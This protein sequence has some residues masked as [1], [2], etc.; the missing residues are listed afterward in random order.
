MSVPS[1]SFSVVTWP[2]LVSVSSTVSILIL[3]TV[4]LLVFFDSL[5]LLDCSLLLFCDALLL[6]LILILLLI[7][8]LILGWSRWLIDVDGGKFSDNVGSSVIV[9]SDGVVLVVNSSSSGWLFR[10]VA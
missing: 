1:L 2:M 3:L 8:L 6:V 9:V 10:G 5:L 4:L 7:L